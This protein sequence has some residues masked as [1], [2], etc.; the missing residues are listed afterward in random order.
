MKKQYGLVTWDNLDLGKPKAKKQPRAAAGTFINLQEG[1]NDLRIVTDPYV[2]T[3]HRYKPDGVKGMG[4]K[5]LCSYPAH[6]SCPLCDVKIEEGEN[7]GKWKYPPQQRAY[8]G[9]ID[10]R[11]NSYKVFDMSSSIL[12]ELKGWNE[13]E[14]IGSPKN[15]DINIEKNPNNPPAQ[16]YRVERYEREPLTEHD[17]E[18]KKKADVEYLKR[19]CTPPT[20]EEVAQIVEKKRNILTRQANGENRP[21]PGQQTQP[22]Q[23]AQPAQPVA[24][25]PQTG[26]A[27]DQSQEDDEFKF[28]PEFAQV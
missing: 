25:P 12:R 26:E 19:K 27:G 4:E 15:Y 5:V 9:V 3:L 10:R 14:R 6:G 7:K 28:P 22:A 8:V 18:E 24:P 11:T 23:P 1:R 17:V 16:F 2:Y 21:S 13:N 20:P